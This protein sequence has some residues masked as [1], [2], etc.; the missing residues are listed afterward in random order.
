AKQKLASGNYPG[1]QAAELLYRQI[2]A[3]RDDSEARAQRA[4]VL[5]QMAF[6]F[7]DSTELA[8]RAMASLGDDASA[9]CA[10]KR[11]GCQDAA[12]AR[13][14]LSMAK[15]E[16]DRASRLAQALRRKFPDASASYLV[17]RAELLL[18]RPDTATD[19]LRTAADGDSHNPLVMHGLGLAEAAA[20]R[21]DRAFEAYRRALSDNANHIAT[22]ID[23][24]LLQVERGSDLEAARGALEGVVG[25]LVGDS[26]PGQLA[27]AFLGLA[28]LELQKGDVTAA[29]R[30]LAQAAAKRRDGDA[31]LSEALA[32]AF[33]D[34]YMLDESEREAKRAIAAAG[35]LTPRLVLAQVALRRAQPIKALAIIEEAGTSRPEAL[36]MRALASL[37]LG[38][39]ES[40]R[41]DAEAALRVQPQGEVAS[42]AKVAL[43]RVDIAD[44]HPDK[45]QRTLAALERTSQKSADVASAM[46]AVFLAEK[47]PDRARWWLQ[48][49]LMR[50][51]LDVE[52]RLQL[53][54]L[55]H[56]TGQ[57]AAARADLNTLLATNAAYA[58]ARREL[59]LV[60]LD[61]G[62]AVAARDELDGLIGDD[63][64]DLETLMN[65]A[66][67]H[68]LLGD[69]QGAEERIQR[70]QKLPTAPQAAEELLDLSARALIVEHRP[71]EAAAQ[72]RKAVPNAMR[73][74]TLALLMDAYLDLEQPERATEVVRAAP[75][76]ARIGVDLLVARSR[77]AIER[78][79]DSVAEGFAQEAIARMRGPRAPRAL[80][81]EAYAILG[82]SQYEQGLFRVAIRSLKTATE[83]D[84][85]MA[86]A[87]Y[88]LGLV[89]QDVSR[90]ADA[91]TA[92]ESAVKA[93][94]LF[95]DAWYYLGR[96]RASLGDP[97]AKEAYAKYLEV[98][99]KG[100]YASEVREALKSEGAPTP[101]VSTP[102]SSRPRIRRRG[103]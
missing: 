12:A 33:A 82:R 76:R 81:A 13:V 69:G 99:P 22:I 47:V 93:D 66:R 103:R 31:L 2:L 23:R 57:F 28:E 26:S 61:T 45:A 49:A 6:E 65:A 55:D 94:P 97:A 64:V 29:R 70:A 17:G 72:L 95:S 38:R 73:G 3:E 53:A 41:L 16:L 80:K 20:R 18:E 90:M 98:A 63:N 91:R 89:D 35:R 37:M 8:Q 58:P 85:R 51:P 96:A 40:A 88:Y 9:P 54:K 100:A 67:A 15:G 11:P 75:L 60:A 79:R 39:K 77:L 7:G 27:R 48:Q 1:F 25:K 87:W 84:P 36:V 21:D 43:A 92:L 44:G 78:G 101:K 74:E 50:D 30:D 32:Q 86:R 34:A 24:A 5:A 10:D 83:L 102:T 59:A 71:A 52:A 4:R 19:A 68:L 42:A 14:Y 62:D 56:D 46:A